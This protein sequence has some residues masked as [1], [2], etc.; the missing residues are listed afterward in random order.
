M[1]KNIINTLIESTIR[2]VENSSR[3]NGNLR[4]GVINE[5]KFP[6]DHV[7]QGLKVH[8]N[9]LDDGAMGSEADGSVMLHAMKNLGYSKDKAQDFANHVNNL[10]IARK[11][12]SGK[13]SDLDKEDLH[14]SLKEESKFPEDHVNQGLKV[15]Q[16][17]LDD[18]AMGSEADGSVMLH[19]MK[20]LGYPRDKAKN[21]ADHVNNLHIAR[22]YTSGPRSSG[23]KE[24]I[25]K[26]LGGSGKYP[27]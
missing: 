25:H 20:K 16:N 4:S 21:F 27:D 22:K 2:F 13:R 14:G 5:A 11:Y 8:Q 24:N 19:A 26:A 12:T 3:N 6:E 17:A 23:D 15:H 9:A 18:G 1:S 10:H 7:N